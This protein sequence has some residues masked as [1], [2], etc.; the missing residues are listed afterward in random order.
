METSIE[1]AKQAG[2]FFE[3]YQWTDTELL[4]LIKVIQSTVAFLE[5]SGP[6]WHL[7]SAPLSRELINFEHLARVRGI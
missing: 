1:E 2:I 4:L 3:Q 5:A 7:A 6:R